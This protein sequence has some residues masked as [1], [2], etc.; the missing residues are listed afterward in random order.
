MVISPEPNFSQAS[1]IVFCSSA[2]ILPLRVIILTL[3]TSGYLL[4]CKQPRALTLLTS[5]GGIAPSNFTFTS[6]R[7][8]PPSND[9]VA[10]KPI[11]LSLF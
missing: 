4:S 5:C 2:V 11:A 9:F 1:Q 3:N 7:E 10:V 6:L 8:T